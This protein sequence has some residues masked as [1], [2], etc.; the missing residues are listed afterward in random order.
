MPRWWRPVPVGR[1][2]CGSCLR[3]RTPSELVGEVAKAGKNFQRCHHWEGS[4]PAGG[5]VRHPRLV[6][7]MS[8]SLLLGRLTDPAGKL[9]KSVENIRECRQWSNGPGGALV[10]Q[11][12]TKMHWL[13]DVWDRKMRDAPLM[14]VDFS[15]KRLN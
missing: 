1:I 14:G 12:A 7:A 13:T 3:F 6:E 5:L 15:W 10:A 9:L 2:P 8:L 11:S 4:T